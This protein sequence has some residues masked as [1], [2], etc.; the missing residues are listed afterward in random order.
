MRYE[1]HDGGRSNYFKKK[2]ADDCVIRAISIATA[3]C[4]KDVYYELMNE[5]MRVGLY[6][7]EPTVWNNYLKRLGWEEVKLGK[8]AVALQNTSL[9]KTAL[10]VTNTHISAVINNT[11]YDTWDCRYRKCWRYW[12]KKPVLRRKGNYTFWDDAA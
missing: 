5:A 12:Q 10:A 9:P 2:V 6:P 8:S 11:L 7:S 3:Q 1:K 4:Y